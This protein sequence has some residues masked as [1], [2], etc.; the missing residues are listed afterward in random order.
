MKRYI[1]SLI[2]FFAGS[3]LLTFSGCKKFLKEDVYTEYD[4]G[5]FLSTEDGIQKVLVGAYSRLQVTDGTMNMRD[6]QFTLPEFPC[7]DFREYAGGFEQLAVPFLNFNWDPTSVFFEQIWSQMYNAVLNSNMLLDNIS[8]IKSIPQSRAAEYIAEARF[9]RA[10]ALEHLYRYFGAVPLITSSKTLDLSPSRPTDDAFRTF[11][12]TELTAAAQ[13]LPVKQ[14]LSGQATKGAALAMLCKFYLNTLQ[15]QKA[16]DAAKSVMDLQA[17]GL[18][19][20]IENLFA[21]QNE[22]NNEYIFVYPCVNQYLYENDYMPHAFPPN[23]PIQSNWENFGAQI[24]LYTSFVKSFD[25]A[26]RRLRMIITFYTDINGVYH[27]LLQDTLGKPLDDSRSFKY[28][29]DPD[30]QGQNNGNDIPVI[31]YADILLSRAEALNELNGPNQESIDLVNQVRQRAGVSLLSL[32]N[33]GSK[34][35]LR[36]WLLQERA[37]EFYGE[38]MRRDDLIRMNK[39]I[40]GAVLRGKTAHDYQVLYPIPQPEIDA[41][42]NLK[43]NPGY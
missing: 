35:A 25:P 43:Q 33:F 15:W 22:N 10:A 11:I 26:D 28:T 5:P 36:D 7:D 29:P 3:V 17:Y 34:D 2:I 41:N 20:A 24:A 4:P 30:A 13:D 39:F 27:N 14:A 16:A 42:P 32:A 9:I 18:F 8:L 37:W 38:G 31:R 6:D 1:R 19:P 40:S 23:Y 21:V 12:E